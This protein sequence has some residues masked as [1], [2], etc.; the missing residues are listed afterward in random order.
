MRAL[1]IAAGAAAGSAALAVLILLAVFPRTRPAPLL[2]VEPTPER[3]ARGRYLF[4]NV[5][6]CA[7]CH[8]GRDATRYGLPV[9]PGTVGAGGMLFDA[10]MG[11]PGSVYSSNIT[12]DPETGLG[13]WSDGEVLRAIRDGV[14]RTGAPLFPIMPY[15]NFKAMADEDAL[16][17]IAYLRALPPIRRAVPARQLAFLPGSLLFRVAP[18]PVRRPVAP[19]KRDGG[20]AYGK[21]LSTIASCGDCHTPRTPLGR[22]DERRALSGGWVM[23]GEWGRVVAANLTPDRGTFV[24]RATRAEFVG[25]FHS[26]A[27]VAANPPA[28]SPGRNTVMPWL[29]YSGMSAEDLGA[30]Y[31]YL[32]TVPP[33]ARKVESFPDAT[34]PPLSLP[35][36]GSP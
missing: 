9:V 1:G 30:I 22:L 14:D 31:D 6:L 36:G 35:E 16:S 2:H 13:R 15:H 27:V 23:E 12:P 21:Y 19:T 25:R 4:W 5:A 18:D 26:F 24:G 7:S 32:R 17:V 8:S 3:L 11:A 34:E 29:A 10:R 28:A 33:I 20:A